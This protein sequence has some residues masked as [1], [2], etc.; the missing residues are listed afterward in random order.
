MD[1]EVTPIKLCEY[2]TYI[3]DILVCPIPN[4]YCITGDRIQK[5]IM[6][7]MKKSLYQILD[8]LSENKRFLINSLLGTSINKYLNC[9]SIISKNLAFTN[10]QV[11][12][13]IIFAE[14]LKNK[15]KYI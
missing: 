13:T 12:E 14:M 1:L 11:E 5:D 7:I 9:T 8:K 10:D 15:F 6:I 2:I 4:N 3:Q